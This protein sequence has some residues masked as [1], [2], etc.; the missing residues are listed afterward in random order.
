MQPIDNALRPTMIIVALFQILAVLIAVT[1][2]F[3]S[4]EV[5]S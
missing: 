1:G 3:R 2:C 4:D 5:F